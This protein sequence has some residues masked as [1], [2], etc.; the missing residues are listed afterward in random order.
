MLS[1]VKHGKLI[2]DPKSILE[3]RL[4][5][6]QL[7]KEIARIQSQLDDPL[8][9][10]KEK[11]PDYKQWRQKAA[12][13]HRHF[14]EEV[15]LLRAWLIAPE[16]YDP[17][18]KLAE[19]HKLVKTIVHDFDIADDLDPAESALIAELDARFKTESQK[20]SIG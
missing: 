8:R 10:L 18:A 16:R 13:A 4:R 19:L 20:S 14:N 7:E 2:E 5:I 11:R 9:N 1:R 15:A 3:A 12:R 6:A 17:E